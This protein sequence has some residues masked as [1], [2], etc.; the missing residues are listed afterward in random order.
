VDKNCPFVEES[1]NTPLFRD[2]IAEVKRYLHSPQGRREVLL[3]LGMVE[4]Y[5]VESLMVIE[6]LSFSDLLAVLEEL[7]FDDRRYFENYSCK[8]HSFHSFATIFMNRGVSKI[9]KLQLQEDTA[10]FSV[11]RDFCYAL[12]F[13]YF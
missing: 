6:R 13:I 4:Q 5:P 11:Q 2:Y 10:F 12:V 8:S 3:N 7:T 9:L 1:K